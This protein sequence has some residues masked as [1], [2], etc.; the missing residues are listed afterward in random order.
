MPRRVE[1]RT[2]SLRDGDN[3]YDYLYRMV[4]DGQKQVVRAALDRLTHGVA[5]VEAYVVHC[6]DFWTNAQGVKV[7]RFKVQNSSSE[8]LNCFEHQP[9]NFNPI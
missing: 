7:E 2:S 1:D 5:E 8:I 4:F 9:P 3:A 6:I